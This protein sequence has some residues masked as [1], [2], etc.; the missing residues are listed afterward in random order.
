MKWFYG[1]SFL[2]LMV[3][4]LISAIAEAGVI[5]GWVETSNQNTMLLLNI[6]KKFNPETAASY[7]ITGVDTEIFDLTPGYI[8]RKKAAY[9][10]AR[11]ELEKRLP[12]V[13]IPEVKQDI[14]ILLLAVDETLE[15]FRLDEKYMLPYFNPAQ[16]VFY[17]LQ[18]LLDDQ[19]EAERRPAALVR[20]KK[21]A[22]L[23]EGYIPLTQNAEREITAKLENKN[24]LGPVKRELERDL[25]NVPR[26]ITGIGQLFDKYEISGYQEALDAF[27]KQVNDYSEFLKENV[28]PRAREDFRLPK[29]YYAFQLKSYGVD[30]P[31]D[32]LVRRAKVSFESLQNDMNGI[33][34][35]FSEK[36]G[37]QIKD[38]KGVIAELKKQQIVGEDILPLYKERIRQLEK[39]ATEHNIVSIPKRDMKIRLASEAESAALPA[40]HMRPPRLIGNTGE[41]GEFVLPLEYPG[42]GLKMDDF[43]YDATS[44]TLAVH[45][46][47]PGHELQFATIVEKGVSLARAIYAFNSVNV[48]GWALYME[49]VMKPYLPLDGQLGALEMLLV[50][51]ARAFLDP[52]LQSGEISK[53]EAMRVLREEVCL[54]EALATQEVE[55]YTFR[56]PGQA[57]SYFCGYQRMLEL[58][59]DVELKLGDKFDLK[60]FHDFVLAQGLLP[61]SV[62]RAA[63]FEHFV[64]RYQAAGY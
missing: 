31:V 58:R 51:S 43:T 5:P 9:Q 41:M 25:D 35:Q 34:I 61:P 55:R 28:L 44:W 6:L 36:N 13:T 16:S 12:E 64:P 20:L 46:G 4:F 15:N 62:L 27:K 52:G 2:S 50:R 1:Y 37:W 8:D 40:P 14:Q 11:A 63:V 42:A 24:L 33:A 22:G 30:M 23:L 26:F 21:Y 32:E 48:E 38:Y 57:T 53:E 39:I 59:A 49:S 7:G 3:V 60:A 56:A 18:A 29:E 47:R 19:I 10:E 17:N 54:S 45:E